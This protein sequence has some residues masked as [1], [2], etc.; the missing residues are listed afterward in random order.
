[1]KKFFFFTLSSITLPIITKSLPKAQ[2]V[3][4]KTTSPAA[5]LHVTDNSV[6]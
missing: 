6:V 4:L 5:R 1:M 3:G 2:N